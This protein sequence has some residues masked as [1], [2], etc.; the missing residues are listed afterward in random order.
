MIGGIDVEIPSLAGDCS[1]EAAVRAIRLHWPSATYENAST[2]DRYSEFS[3]IPFGQLDEL[4]VYRDRAAAELWDAEGA[5]PATANTMVHLLAEEGHL[6]VAIDIRD[7]DMNRL[8]NVVATALSDAI[9]A[10]P[11]RVAA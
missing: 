4:F 2:G 10:I 1:I 8:L 9:H 6:I 7:A 11:A 3:D 5:T